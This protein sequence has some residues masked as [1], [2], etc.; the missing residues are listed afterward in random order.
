MRKRQG[1][2]ARRS[3]AAVGGPEP[4]KKTEGARQDKPSAERESPGTEVDRDTSEKV[5]SWFD[6]VRSGAQLT[7]D[8]IRVIREA[9]DL[10]RK[11]SN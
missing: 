3:D 1:R 2:A 9:T 11:L 6:V 7:L 4:V 5:F 10:Y 8:V